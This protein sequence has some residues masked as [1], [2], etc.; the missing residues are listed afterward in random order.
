MSRSDSPDEQM[1]AVVQALAALSAEIL[2]RT[3]DARAFGSWYLVFRVGAQVFRVVFDGK[4]RTC[5]LQRSITEVPPYRWV[6]TGWS[7]TP[8]PAASALVGA[9]VAAIRGASRC[10]ER[11]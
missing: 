8:A 9:L 1:R 11:S 7:R 5:E 6:A 3:Y 10:V 4:D 2:E